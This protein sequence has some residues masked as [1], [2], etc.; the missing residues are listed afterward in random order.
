MNSLRWCKVKIP[1]SCMLMK[2]HDKFALDQTSKITSSLGSSTD[3]KGPLVSLLIVWGEA[4]SGFDLVVWFLSIMSSLPQIRQL[5]PSFTLGGWPLKHGLTFAL[6]Q[7]ESAFWGYSVC[8]RIS[9]CNSCCKFN[10]KFRPWR[11]WAILLKFFFVVDQCTQRHNKNLSQHVWMLLTKIDM[12]YRPS[13]Y[14]RKG[15]KRYQQSLCVKFYCDTG[16]TWDLHSP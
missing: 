5:K 1:S 16:Q 8:G 6:G 13:A 15:G 14:L 11:S 12:P 3:T 10:L 4:N 7:S 9:L 2:H